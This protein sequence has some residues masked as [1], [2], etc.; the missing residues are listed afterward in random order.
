MFTLQKL[1]CTTLRPTQLPYISLYNW[2]GCADFV[3]DY[4]NFE[5]LNPPV[6]LVSTLSELIWLVL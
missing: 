3:A 4:L 6:D 1:V 5:P 2:D